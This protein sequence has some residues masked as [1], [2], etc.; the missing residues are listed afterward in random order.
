[1]QPARKEDRQTSRPNQSPRNRVIAAIHLTWRKLRPDLRHSPEE[2]RDERLAFITDRLKL[3]RPL[4]SMRSLSTPQLCLALEE[5]R[6]L[7]SEPL[8]PN[9]N[10]APVKPIVQGGAEIIHLASAEQVY[11]INKLFDCLSWGPELRA[12]FLKKRFHRDTPSML[13]PQ[14]AQATVMILLN[15]AA[16]RAIRSRGGVTR[17]TRGMIRVEIPAL[18]ARLG[19]DRKQASD[20][21]EVEP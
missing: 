14:Q 19:I 1:M 7:I 10:A 18:K 21:S 5:M 16:A 2:L 6:R 9:S 8:L 12:G 3:K 11:T 20:A 4:K 13:S 17:V 15:I